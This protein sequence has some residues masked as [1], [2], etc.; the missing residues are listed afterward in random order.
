M[1]KCGEQSNLS[2]NSIFLPTICGQLSYHSYR[3]FISRTA[4]AQEHKCVTV[5]A[6]G[7]RFDPHWRK[8][9]I[10][11]NL[12]F[13]FVL[14]SRQNATLSSKPQHAMPPEF[15]WGTECFP[16]GALCLHWCVRDTAWSWFDLI[17][18]L[19]LHV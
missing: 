10:H 4:V 14:V 18:L 1:L 3:S 7:C 5:N 11:L 9:N 16:L 2:Q 19:Y 15:Q 12:Y 8:Y 17:Y 6:T 13:F